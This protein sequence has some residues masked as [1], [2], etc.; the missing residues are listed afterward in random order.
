[1]ITT[2]PVSIS[3]SPKIETTPLVN[4]SLIASTSLSTRVISRPTGLRSK[5][6]ASS[7]CRWANSVARR[8]WITRWPVSCV[9]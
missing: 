3:T 7:D 1:M 4:S 6:R 5:N 8:S 2:T 9:T